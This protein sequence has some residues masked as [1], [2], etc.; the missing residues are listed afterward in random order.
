[1]K[2]L[3]ACWIALVTLLAPVQAP[4]QGAAEPRAEE[5]ARALQKKYDAV[6]DFT[7]DFQHLYTGGM[8]RKQLSERGRLQIKK[9]GKMR[10]EYTAPEKKTFVSDGLKLYAYVPADQQVI[11]SSAQ[12][13]GRSTTPV[14]FLA[15]QGDLTRD[16][17]ISDT[18]PP[19]GLPAGTRSLKLVPRVAQPEFE[20]LILSV[21][22]ETFSLRGLSSE[23]A[24]GGTSAFLFANL[25]ENVGMTDKIFVFMMPRGVDVVSDESTGGRMSP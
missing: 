24:Q 17:T 15:G 6:R 5:F 2:R 22:R 23:D 25:K 4:V 19:S 1:M 14:L 20:S 9:P 10:W 8:L 3:L 13:A 12:P 18:A 7:A 16:F 11:V 21:D